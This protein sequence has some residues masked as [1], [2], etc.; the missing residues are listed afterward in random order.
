MKITPWVLCALS[1]ICAA[2]ADPAPATVSDADPDSGS[3]DSGNP[4]SGSPDSGSPDA[5]GLDSGDLD[6]DDLDAPDGDPEPAGPPA[7]L[8]DFSLGSGF[9]SAP[10]PCESRR[11][12]DG[13]VDLAGFPN[14]T[15]VPLVA[16]LVEMLERDARG[17]STSASIFFQL[18][19]ALDPAS[20]PDLHGS[21]SP[22]SPALIIDVDPI[23]PRR[24]SRF[25]FTSGFQADGGPFGA[26]NLLGL[27][28][29][30]GTP[31]DERTLYA[32]ILT[33]DLRTASGAPL[34][35]SPQMRAILDG[36][37]PDGLSEAAFGD[38]LTALAALD[39]AAVDRARIAAMTVFRTD[40]PAAPMISARQ[41]ALAQPLPGPEAPFQPDEIFEDYCVYSTTLQMPTYQSGDPPFTRAGG[42][43]EFDP[44]GALIPQ[45]FERARIV[46]TLPRRPMPPEGFPTA[47]FVRTGG[48]GDRPLVDRGFRPTAGGP[49]EAPGQG[50]ALHFARAGWAGVSVDGPHG[51]LRN[52]NGADEQLLVFNVGNPLALRDNIRQSALELILTAHLISTL[53]I[54]ADACPDLDADGGPARLDAGQLALMGHSMGATIGPLAVA[55]EPRLK[56]MIL[57][58]GGGSYIANVLFKQKPIRIRPVARALLGYRGRDLHEHDP[59]LNLLQWAAEPADPPTYASRIIWRPDPDAAP[60]QVLM[61]QGIADTYI[62][63]PMANALSLSLGL[64]LAGDPLDADHP[65]AG[66]FTPL[67]EVLDLS[68]RRTIPLPASANLLVPGFDPTTGV[69]VQH[70]E[71]PIED[72]HEVVF[73]TPGPKHQYRCFLESLTRG[74]PSVPAHQNEDSPCDP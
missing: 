23:S 52:F 55:A 7:A 17:F 53:E 31:L 58:G 27:L 39:E 2:C 44:Q 57:S 34:T 28:P 70:P 15:G 63:P 49:P 45:G 61:L 67:S 47:I 65:V 56:A 43:W 25:A 8:M 6:A 14:P 12:E 29:M 59:A 30:Q 16:S 1:L 35:P 54:A 38:F 3:P 11:L 24:L 74:A 9:Y 21:L 18:T 20:L 66:Q 62:L 68:G 40:A 4:D 42:G 72:G 64:D 32:A 37:R 46:V 26:P 60:R 13:R 41:S 19:E 69:V 5:G 73:Q 33:T 10:M 71:D 50:P 48:G 51:G 22:Q 36:R